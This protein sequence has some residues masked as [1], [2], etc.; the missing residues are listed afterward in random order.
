MRDRKE[1]TPLTRDSEKLAPRD[2]QLEE[3]LTPPSTGD[4]LAGAEAKAS[5]GK[6]GISEPPEGRR[7][8]PGSRE[9]LGVR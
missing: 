8:E 5:G 3:N 2:V 4:G 9:G 7:R 1:G 6:D